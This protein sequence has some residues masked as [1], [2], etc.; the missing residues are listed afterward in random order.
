[1]GENRLYEMQFMAPKTA[2]TRKKL[3]KMQFCIISGSL[4]QPFNPA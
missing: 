1:L 4:S 2:L 3:H